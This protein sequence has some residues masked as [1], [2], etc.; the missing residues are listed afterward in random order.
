MRWSGLSRARTWGAL[1]LCVVLTGACKNE[2]GQFCP[3]PYT[4]FARRAPPDIGDDGL[5]DTGCVG[6]TYP[7]WTWRSGRGCWEAGSTFVCD[8]RP[9]PDVDVVGR[10]ADGGCVAARLLPPLPRYDLIEDTAGSCDELVPPWDDAGV[11]C[12]PREDS[13]RTPTDDSEPGWEEP[14][15]CNEQFDACMSECDW[16]RPETCDR[17]LFTCDG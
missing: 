17:C 14:T 3:K 15:D 11:V 6:Q 12:A 10:L 2:D 8:G 5:D 4:S 9:Q 1:A 7:L 16:C 13:G